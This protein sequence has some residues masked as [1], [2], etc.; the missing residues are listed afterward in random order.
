MLC[1]PEGHNPVPRVVSLLRNVSVDPSRGLAPRPLGVGFMSRQI[2]PWLSVPQPAVLE[3]HLH[4][5]RVRIQ[6]LEGRMAGLETQLGRLDRQTQ[7][8]RTQLMQVQGWTHEV[9]E[10]LAEVAGA[11]SM[12]AD[13]LAGETAH[14]VREAAKP[15]SAASLET[16]G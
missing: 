12:M 7:E 5:L 15:A 2:E 8:V 3:E 11:L 16:P 1:Y 14:R 6:G 13:D 9:E 10:Q 4:T